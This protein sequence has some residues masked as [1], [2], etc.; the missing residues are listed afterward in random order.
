MS[1]IDSIIEKVQKLLALAKSSNINEA[2]A[3]TAA[4]NKLIDQYR[5]SEADLSLSSEDDQIVE[6]DGFVYETGRIIPWKNSLAITLAK[7]YGCAMFNSTIYPNGRKVSRYKL[8][9]KK[10]D[11]QITKYMFSWLTAECNRLLEKEAYGKGKIFSQSYCQGFVSGVSQQLVQS[12]AAAKQEAS[13]SAII[14]IDAREQEAVSFMNKLYNLKSSKAHSA[15]RIDPRAFDAGMS[16][17]K[18]IHLGQSLNN[19]QVKLLNS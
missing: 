4:A 18:S 13:S 3:A 2:A 8:I 17:G 19:K 14:K 10:S 11:I 9:G 1:K 7:H 15:S 6:D 16:K 12:R 5:L